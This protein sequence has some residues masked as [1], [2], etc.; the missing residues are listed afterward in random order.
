M[1]I[2]LDQR[3]NGL[4][5]ITPNKKLDIEFIENIITAHQVKI[6]QYRP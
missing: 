4:Y 6:L 2:T 3:I 5:G 1:A